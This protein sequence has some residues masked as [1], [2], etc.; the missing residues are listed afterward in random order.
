MTLHLNLRAPA[1]FTGADVGLLPKNVLIDPIEA[2]GS[3]LLTEAAHPLGGWPAGGVPADQTPFTNLFEAQADSVVGVGDHRAIFSKAAS[4]SG[5]KGVVE[6]TTKSGIHVIVSPT[7]TMTSVDFVNLSAPSLKAYIKANKTHHFYISTWVRWTKAGVSGTAVWR[8]VFSTDATFILYNSQTVL[9][10]TSTAGGTKDG[11]LES[12]GTLNAQ[13]LAI[14]GTPVATVDTDADTAGAS[15]G[16]KN[17]A[18]YTFSQR[19]PSQLNKQG[20]SVLYRAYVEDLT[21]SGRS[22]DVPAG[23]DAALMAKHCRTTGGRYYGDT[24]PTD[25]ATVA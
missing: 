10:T 11:G 7:V 16:W 17:Q 24:W 22:W 18:L 8:T 3:L 19:Q 4:F 20:A 9:A 12:D 15:L 25:P 6:R 1:A 13:V 2:P 14:A 23:I 5:G 21:V